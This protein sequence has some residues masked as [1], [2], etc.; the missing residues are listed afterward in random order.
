MTHAYSSFVVVRRALRVTQL[1]HLTNV[2]ESCICDLNSPTDDQI[3]G[4][5]I[6][7]QG[8]GKEASTCR[9]DPS[10]RPE[11][12]VL[13]A[14]LLKAVEAVQNEGFNESKG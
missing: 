10:L 1:A 9:L 14:E 8:G 2:R 13:L 5:E 6:S 7:V 11:K 12:P 4:Y 3:P